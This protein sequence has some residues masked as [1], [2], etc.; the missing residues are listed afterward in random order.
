MPAPSVSIK[1][2]DALEDLDLT[3][4]RVDGFCAGHIFAMRET[5]YEANGGRRAPLHR[6]GSFAVDVSHLIA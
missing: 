4:A 6:E 1:H 2:V 5:V 3:R